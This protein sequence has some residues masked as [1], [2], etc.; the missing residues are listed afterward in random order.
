MSD[1]RDPEATLD[2]WKETMQAEHAEAIANPDPDEDHHIEGVTQVSHRVTF[3][4]DPDA[5]S[6]ERDEIE[7]VDELTDP[8]LLS[9]AC[10]V[11]GMT[12]EEAREHIRAARESADE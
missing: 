5:D 6:L 10:D 8:E 7:R 1:E 11:R 2:E 4:Y 12:P 3:E 9:C